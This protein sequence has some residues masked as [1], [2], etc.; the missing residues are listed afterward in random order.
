MG[1]PDPLSIPAYVYHAYNL[2]HSFV[3]WGVA[4][5]LL[6]AYQRTR[7]KSSEDAV[8]PLIPF[9][10]W[11]LHIMC[12]IPT[13]SLRFFP[14]PFLWPLSTPFYDGT[15]WGNRLFMMMNYSALVGVYAVYFFRRS[16]IQSPQA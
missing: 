10:A 12:D 16:K 15:P 6:W 7:G 13:H 11:P 9:F 1:P 5:G 4:F 14:T 3:V 2:T 8:T